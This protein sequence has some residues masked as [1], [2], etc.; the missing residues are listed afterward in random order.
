MSRNSLRAENQESLKLKQWYFGL[1]P[2]KKAFIGWMIEQGIIKNDNET[3]MILDI[4][5]LSAID[6]NTELSLLD[7]KKIIAEANEYMKDYK[8][9]LEKYKEEGLNMIE[10]QEIIN[11]VTERI[12]V[13]R[14]EKVDKAKGLKILKKEFN[15]PFAELS[16][17]W[18]QS[19]G[20]I[21]NSHT[22]KKFKDAEKEKFLNEV[23]AENEKTC[24][25]EPKLKVVNTIQEIKGE[26]G[27]YV[28]SQAGVRLNE[29][30]YKDITDVEAEK[31]ARKSQINALEEVLKTQLEE[32]N[33]KLTTLAENK[34][35]EIDKYSEILEVF[36]M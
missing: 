1:P 5:F 30:L 24:K 12:K 20:R 8:E 16:D 2:S 21:S 4:C 15:L 29:K 18:I 19:K 25:K 23:A 22:P 36:N 7:L 9:Y 3:A 35:K 11:K 32:V 31:E 28:K 26:Y 10:N 34:K 27:T 14:S 33:K 6:D 13:L 17:I